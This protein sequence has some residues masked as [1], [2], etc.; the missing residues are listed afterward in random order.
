MA[1]P[2]PNTFF[3]GLADPLQRFTLQGG[4]QFTLV[5]GRAVRRVRLVG[6]FFDTDKCFLR[7]SAMA[8]IRGIKQEFDQHPKSN[9]L[10][11]GHT[12]TS[13]KDDH[14][15]KLSVER[16]KAV[17]AFL[18]DDVDA[19]VAHFGDESG[20]VSNTW[21]TT[22]VQAMLSALP[23]G[24]KPFLAPEGVDGNDGPQTKAAIRQ[25]QEAK[26]LKADGIAG[27]VTQRAVITDYMA[28]QDT[29]FPGGI[30]ITVHG[31]G[32]NFPVA[33]TNDGKRSPEDRRVEMFFF[34]GPI[35]PPPPGETSA[36]GSDEYP[37]W[38]AAVTN[39]SDFTLGGAEPTINPFRYGFPIG[40][41]SPW[42]PAAIFRVVGEGDTDERRFSMDQGIA[43]DDYRIFEVVN[44]R[45][46]LKYRG[47]IEEGDLSVQVFGPAELS[48]IADPADPLNQL[49]LPDAPP[50]DPEGPP[51]SVGPVAAS[52]PDT[53][54]DQQAVADATAADDSIP[55]SIGFA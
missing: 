32:E 35:A 51:D 34:D 25:F 9:L 40:P 18:T 53:A 30:T 42:S 3:Q 6:M 21:S 13:G 43:E 23:E 14:N 48:R 22:E 5:I 45:P 15:L 17:E 1:D 50:D 26:G 8:G 16:A 12:D 38:V 28:L 33:E 46:G 37:Q 7:P 11:V 54:V 49:P 24:G 20:R 47:F 2:D 29:S 41:P 55:S 44:S 10:I 19:W 4:T 27:P 31:C 36:K 39:T 52:G